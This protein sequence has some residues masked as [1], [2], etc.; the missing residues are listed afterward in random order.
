MWR[1]NKRLKGLWFSVANHRR[2]KWAE[3]KGK[4]KWLPE[5]F[6][7]LHPSRYHS[8]TSVIWTYYFMDASMLFPYPIFIDFQYLCIIALYLKL[9]F[10]N[11]PRPINKHVYIANATENFE[12]LISH[13]S[14]IKI[15]EFNFFKII[16]RKFSFPLSSLAYLRHYPWA[17]CL[18]I[19]T[20]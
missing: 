16:I 4:K 11:T 18:D 5:I 9:C 1:N 8:L 2:E 3:K 10:I 14:S 20:H 13:Y 7:D 6:S 19:H 17:P 12:N 15:W